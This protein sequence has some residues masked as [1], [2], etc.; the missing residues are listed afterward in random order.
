MKPIRE[1]R[2]SKHTTTKLLGGE[3][4]L[5]IRRVIVGLRR[6]YDDARYLSNRMLDQTQ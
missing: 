5:S 3:S 4:H 2:S 1:P 6:A